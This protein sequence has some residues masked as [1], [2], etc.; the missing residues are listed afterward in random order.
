VAHPLREWNF[1]ILFA[2]RV[3]DALGDAAGPVLARSLGFAWPLSAAAVLVVI[4][5]VI[6]AFLPSV[7]DLRLH[8]AEKE[9]PGLRRRRTGGL[10]PGG[11]EGAPMPEA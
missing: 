6:P 1:R 11:M 3:V 9:S 10:G 8:Y 7:R 4:T 5:P 2:G